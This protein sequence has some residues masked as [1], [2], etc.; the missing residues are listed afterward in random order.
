MHLLVIGNSNTLALLGAAHEISGGTPG[1]ELA[2]SWAN[3]EFTAH[4]FDFGSTPGPVTRGRFVVIGGAVKPPIVIDALG[5]I[6]MRAEYRSALD[7][8]VDALDGRVDRIASCFYGGAHVVLSLVEHAVPFDVL[9]DRLDRGVGENGSPRQIVPASVMKRI[10]LE[11][12]HPTVVACRMLRARFPQAEVMHVTPPPPVRDEEFLRGVLP[13]VMQT[14]VA[15]R[16]IAPADLRARI[17]RMAIEA[18][19]TELSADHVRVVPPP[20]L[21]EDEG[22][23]RP[24]YHLDAT[25]ANPAYGRLVLAQVGVL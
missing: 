1:E 5:R 24:E 25:H 3:G 23:L 12:F 17:H 14:V 2:T 21:A 9:P 4:D 6:T 10:L 15:E 16:G 7:A 20:T 18:L 8:A 19:S 22:F 11:R 13:A